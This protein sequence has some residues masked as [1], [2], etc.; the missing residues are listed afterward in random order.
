PEPLCQLPFPHKFLFPIFRLFI[1][2]LFPQPHNIM[3]RDEE[4]PTRPL[5]NQEHLRS[6]HSLF[7]YR[8]NIHGASHKTLISLI[9][10]LVHVIDTILPE[11]L[12]KDEYL[13]RADK[14]PVTEEVVKYVKKLAEQYDLEE[15][16][17]YAV[18]RTTTI[19]KR[20]GIRDEMKYEVCQ[21]REKIA[22]FL[23]IQ[24]VHLFP[25]RIQLYIQ[26]L[27]KRYTAVLGTLDDDPT[28]AMEFALD[29]EINDFIADPHVVQCVGA[30]WEGSV[31]L[32]EEKD[33]G[34]LTPANVEASF[35]VYKNWASDD[36]WTH[37]DPVRLTVPKYQS[38]IELSLFIVFLA[39]YT[40]VINNVRQQ[41][42]VLEW[43]LYLFVFGYIFDDI[44]QL[45][46]GGIFYLQQLWNWLNIIFVIFFLIAF[47][48]R[49]SS[50]LTTDEDARRRYDDT[51]YDLMATVAVVLWMRVLT[52]LDGIRFVGTMTVVLESMIKEGFLFFFMAAWIFIG[53]VQTFYALD[54]DVNPSPTEIVELL[55]K[56][57]FQQ[58]DFETAKR[59]HPILGKG[60]LMV[61]IF[62]SLTILLNLLIAL[63][64][65]SYSKISAAAHAE[66]LKRFAYKVFRYLRAEDHYPFS[67]PFNLL[68]V[69]VIIPLG[70]ILTPRAYKR[71]NKIILTGIFGL[72]LLCVGAYEVWRVRSGASRKFTLDHHQEEPVHN[73]EDPPLGEME[74]S[75]IR[76]AV[77]A[78][79]K[80]PVLEALIAIQQ[81]Q[82]AL[83]AEIEELKRNRTEFGERSS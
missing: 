42:L 27:T 14:T 58:P 12:I 35:V 77:N 13:T 8:G 68:E 3:T 65:D 73:L 21:Q 72:V 11:P 7:S 19:F 60:L 49:V 50:F 10:K 81:E 83:K 40:Y 5:L 44:R 30:L 17:V 71:L 2:H 33:D 54:D 15:A 74:K 43:V 64:N 28:S 38:L 23:A 29:H 48:Y 79:H 70:V 66:Y 22:Q 46:K 25:D 75:E 47:T 1:F 39:L 31:L 62:T 36:F 52:M 51:A 76:R 67:V 45:Y 82:K 69:F 9:L 32:A 61:Y 53:F 37:V 80:D 6:Y 41:P 56:A 59:Y 26:V 16:V 24:L 63:F 57:F 20:E 55:L 34:T 4:A 78:G 18:L